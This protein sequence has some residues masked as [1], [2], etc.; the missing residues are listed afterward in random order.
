MSSLQEQSVRQLLKWGADPFL[1]DSDGVNS[2][3]LAERCRTDMS[4]IIRRH[5]VITASDHDFLIMLICLAGLAALDRSK[6]TCE[7]C[8]CIQNASTFQKSY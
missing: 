7:A 3:M 2:V 5:Q 4:T 6:G 8:N 1:K